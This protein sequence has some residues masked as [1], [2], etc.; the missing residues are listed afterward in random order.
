MFL[1]VKI[2]KLVLPHSPQS[3]LRRVLGPMSLREELP[4]RKAERL[5]NE[6]T[7]FAVRKRWTMTKNL[8]L[9]Y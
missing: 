7:N 1:F 2:C 6:S 4:V 8:V 5:P 9:H 3:P